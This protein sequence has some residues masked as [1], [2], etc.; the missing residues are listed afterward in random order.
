M[1]T[2]AESVQARDGATLL[3]IFLRGG[4][5][6]RTRWALILWTILSVGC[7]P[8]IEGGDADP[9]ADGGVTATTKMP[10]SVAVVISEIMYHPVDETTD[11]EVHEFVELHN[12]SG[13]A[14]DLGGW[15]LDSDKG[16]VSFAFPAGVSIAA[17][18]YRVVAKNRQALAAV[19]KYGLAQAD[20]LG[21]YAGELDNGGATLSLRDPD[22]KVVD[23]VKYSDQFPWPIA[24]DALGVGE[25]WL[26]AA[27]RP[28]VNHR[29]MG[30]SLERV[31]ADWMAGTPANWEASPLDGATPGRASSVAGPV[32]PVAE[33]AGA[34][35]EDTQETLIRS[36]QKIAFRA[37][38]SAFAPVS[39]VQLEYFVDD[40]A[41]AGEPTTTAPMTAGS[42]GVF[43]A[44]LGP[45]KDSTL[46]RW[47]VRATR[48]G[49]AAVLA[50]RATDP[51]AWYTAFVTPKAFVKAGVESKERTYHLWITPQDW[52]TL[53]KWIAPGRAT[54][55]AGCMVNADWQSTVPATFVAD[56]KAY[57]VRVRYEGSRYQRNNGQRIAT[58]TVPG[59]TT[60]DGKQ[61][62]AL[63]WRIKFPKYDRFGGLKEIA[64]NKLNQGC[65]GTISYV[66]SAMLE[67]AG[68]PSYRFAFAR[69]HINGAY[70]HYMGQP[71]DIDEGLFT[72]T[73][74]GEPVGDLFK[75]DGPGGDEGPAARGDYTVIKGP[76]PSCTQYTIADRYAATYRRVTYEYRPYDEMIQ[77]ITELAAA[78]AKGAQAV[79]DYFTKYWEVDSLAA[80]FVVRNWSG[81]WDDTFHNTFPYKRPKTGKWYLLQQDYE[82][83]LGLGKLNLAGIVGLGTWNAAQTLYIGWNSPDANVS[84]SCELPAG[85]TAGCNGLGFSSLKDAFI[86]AF[87]AEI[88]EKYRELTRKGILSADGVNALID[89]AAA[90]FSSDDWNADP[91]AKACDVAQAH[92]IMRAWARDRAAT[93]VQRLKP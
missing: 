40:I 71:E 1:Q 11:E 54:G 42:D 7:S 67:K 14:V 49:Q 30:R 31:S 29:Y 89:E 17:G 20:L 80:A 13:K 82:G 92:M 73:W 37:R 69:L 53:E 66:E 46:V 72:R 55:T 78:R 26:P 81:V 5:M 68:V 39:D 48:G 21:D 57:D 16:G 8:K 63:S 64:L 23:G 91:A 19:K 51:L 90:K 28:L 93:V 56:G 60:A 32:L 84:K 34:V 3:E 58:W 79:R 86:G 47:R 12:R 36:N 6:T 4:A 15:K 24:A 52:T 9:A 43:A 27:D 70:Y 35:A 25:D 62:R 76:N 44:T 10:D 74:P 87:R 41:A 33:L 38:F 50:P 65:P 85:M 2:D 83:D 45:F 61:L 22:G 18:Q 77:L 88:D 59:P 75:D